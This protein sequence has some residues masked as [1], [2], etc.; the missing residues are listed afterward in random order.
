MAFVAT[1]GNNAS[2][3]LGRDGPSQV[4]QMVP[5]TEDLVQVCCGH[6]HTVVL[7]S[8][9]NVFG[10]GRNVEG[11]LG[12]SLDEKYVTSPRQLFA[13]QSEV[14]SCKYLKV[15]A[16]EGH[17]MLLTSDGEIMVVGSGAFGQLGNGT[18]ATCSVTPV[19]VHINETVVDISCGA[20][21]CFAIT[22]V[23]AV[24]G[25]GE[26]VSGMFGTPGVAIPFIAKP[27]RL[28][29]GPSKTRIARVVAS[30]TFAT[31]VTVNCEAIGAGNN[32][33]GQ[34]YSFD[35]ES[36]SVWKHMRYP[37]KVRDVSCGHN[38]IVALL[39]NGKII[40]SGGHKLPS[41][42]MFS[43]DR[44]DGCVGV[45]AGRHRTFCWDHDGILYTCGK[46]HKGQ[47]GLGHTN[48]QSTVQ[49]VPLPQSMHAVGVSCGSSHTAVLLSDAHDSSMNFIL[50]MEDMSPSEDERRVD[51]N[52]WDEDISNV[53]FSRAVRGSGPT[54]AIPSAV[55]M[56]MSQSTRML[57]MS[58]TENPTSKLT[59]SH[60][61]STGADC[62]DAFRNTKIVASTVFI[63]IMMMGVGISLARSMRQSSWPPGR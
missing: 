55:A 1:A 23:G 51:A 63:A 32:V 22:S 52:R 28:T 29:I 7:S 30:E 10:W 19:R 24:Y 11:Q 20:R 49:Q 37:C 41:G 44:V 43:M 42:M 56:A 53:S 25:W 60:V 40:Q 9:G 17:T 61:G 5:V 8:Q 50:A 14:E 16:G 35:G 4:F 15:A 2:G 45:A 34:L 33:F 46:N 18:C 26:S 54:G 3:Q 12:L 62:H 59:P 27:L 36:T 13:D 47:L 39:Q 21:S 31:F 58:S 38:H 6:H 48:D 57:G